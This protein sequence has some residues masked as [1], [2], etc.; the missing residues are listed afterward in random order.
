MILIYLAFL[1]LF[2]TVQLLLDQLDHQFAFLKPILEGQ[3]LASIFDVE[4]Q[5]Y[6]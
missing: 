6:P 4:T 2:S 5:G 3:Y 1:S